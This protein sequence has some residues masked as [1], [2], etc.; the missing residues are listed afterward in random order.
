M[1]EKYTNSLMGISPEIAANAISDG[2][3]D[4]GIDPIYFDGDNNELF[5]VNLSG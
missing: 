5:F 3:H 1:K 2:Y 4:N